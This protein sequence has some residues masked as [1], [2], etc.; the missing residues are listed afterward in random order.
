M[1]RLL[2][3]SRPTVLWEVPGESAAPAVLFL[4][5]AGERGVDGWSALRHGLPSVLARPRR[6]GIRVLVP[7]CPPESRWDDRV[8]D[9]ARSLDSLCIGALAVTGFSM[10]GQGVAESDAIVTALRAHGRPPIYTRYP[11]LGHTETCATAYA[12]DAYRVWLVG[13]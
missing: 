13:C 5:G 8:E 4:H 10:G 9:V 7:Q 3:L 6:E 1:W 11:D 12:D 2:D